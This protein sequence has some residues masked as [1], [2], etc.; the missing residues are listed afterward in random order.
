MPVNEKGKFSDSD[1]DYR[2]GITK[3][4]GGW[5][6]DK[7]KKELKTM[8]SLAEQV[9]FYKEIA[10]FDTPEEF[11]QH[12]CYHGSGGGISNLKPSIALPRGSFLGGGYEERYFT[13][14]L[15]KDR[16]IAS[17]FTGDSRYGSVAPVLLRRGT[18]IKNLPEISDSN[19]LTDIISD[20]WNEGIDAVV[21]GDHSKEHSEREI[22][23]LNPKCIVVGPSH[24]FQVYHKEKTPS[25]TAEEIEALW[26]N[27]A[28]KYKEI[29]IK[30]WE[31]KN[32]AFKKKHGRDMNSESWSQERENLYQYHQFNKERYL[33]KKQS[34]IN[35][36]E[37]DS[38]TDFLLSKT[39]KQSPIESISKK[40]P[41]LK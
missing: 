28:D 31:N 19:Q 41:K 11:A 13:I 37:S 1:L 18:I 3:V 10:K 17:N 32:E 8:Q 39:H 21:L 24:S 12:L 16:E 5:T 30:N 7:V 9:S 33:E 6:Q 35:K 4:R 22:S 27:S 38:I 23:V 25:F 15:S 26:L 36:E 40:S 2:A 34:L 20:L 14:S 29:S